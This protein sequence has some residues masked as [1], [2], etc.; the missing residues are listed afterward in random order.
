VPRLE[1]WTRDTVRRV[2]H[3]LAAHLP[4]HD[5]AHVTI[6]ATTDAPTGRFNAHV[7][8]EVEARGW[9]VTVVTDGTDAGTWAVPMNPVLL[10]LAAQSPCPLAAVRESHAGDQCGAATMT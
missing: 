10:D 8:F 1:T 3:E 7:E 5:D 2:L 6:R 9:R 4:P